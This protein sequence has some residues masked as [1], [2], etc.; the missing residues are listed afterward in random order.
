[1]NN[2]SY[3]PFTSIFTVGFI[4]VISIIILVILLYN[5]MWSPAIII[6][7]LL[8]ITE[9][10]KWWSKLGLKK[11]NIKREFSPNRLFPGEKASLKIKIENNKM[12]PVILE[13]QQKL[14]PEVGENIFKR[15]AIK[16]N[17]KNKEVLQISGLKRGYYLLGELAVN[18]RDGLG[19]YYSQYILAR[20]EE[21]FVYPKIKSIESFGIKAADLIGE[22]LDR[23]P[24]LPDPLRV[25]G[26]CDYTPNMPARLIH[27]K[28]STQKD[29]LLAKLLEPSADFKLLF[30]IDVSDF[31]FQEDEE[32]FEEALSKV[33]SLALWAEDKRIPFGLLVNASQK[34]LEGA[35]SVPINLGPRQTTLVLEKL[36]RLEFNPL[37]NLKELLEKER[38]NITWGTTLV[39]TSKTKATVTATGAR[40]TIYLF[41]D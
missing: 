15:V 25:A 3:L 33:A 19:L 24:I 30:V 31:Y 7:F 21:L 39:V 28:A 4:K 9:G 11:L 13:Y 12:L 14:P 2:E 26:L 34:G 23:R 27:W 10:A 40:H 41:S 8:V 16:G 29:K 6:L 32:G 1:V 18:S 38:K 36:A 17:E 20:E 5:A 22:H 37:G 35:V